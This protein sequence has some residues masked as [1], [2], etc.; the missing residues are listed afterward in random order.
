ML[1]SVALVAQGKE[2]CDCASVT[3]TLW[4]RT[5]PIEGFGYKTRTSPPVH[6]MESNGAPGDCTAEKDS[7]KFAN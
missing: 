5:N 6:L 4:S 7:P 1:M 2:T 3:V